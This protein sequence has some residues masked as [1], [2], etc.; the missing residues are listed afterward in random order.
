MVTALPCTHSTAQP[1][2]C[3]TCS[4][5]T[6]ATL[7]ASPHLHAVLHSACC[8]ALNSL[9]TSTPQGSVQFHSTY[10][11]PLAF[12][13]V[14]WCAE[15]LGRD[16]Y[17]VSQT[18]SHALQPCAAHAVVAATCTP[19]ILLTFLRGRAGTRWQRRLLGSICLFA[20]FESKVLIL[21]VSG[22]AFLQAQQPSYML[23]WFHGIRHSGIP[24]HSMAFR[25]LLDRQPW[26][27]CMSEMPC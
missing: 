26:G 10:H 21:F 17:E 6:Y 4:C 13:E 3:T 19:V 27:L 8:M 16:P 23:S 9:K 14:D 15:G 7:T 24:W 22:G 11:S 20:R 25:H 12:C 5:D 18:S 1:V 2:T